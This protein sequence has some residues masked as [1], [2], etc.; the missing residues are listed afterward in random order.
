MNRLEEVWGED[1]KEWKP[2]R[3]MK[4]LNLEVGNG[5]KKVSSPYQ[6]SVKI[7]AAF[8]GMLSFLGGG[9]ACM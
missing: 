9:R 4:D 7:P 2:E 1:A 3:W 6:S 5:E 8:S